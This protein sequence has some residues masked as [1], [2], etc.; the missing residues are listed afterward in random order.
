MKLNF[1]FYSVLC[2][3]LAFTSLSEAADTGVSNI[4]NRGTVYCGTNRNHHDLA[5]KDPNDNT[6]RGFDAALCRA[7][8]AALLGNKERFEMKPLRIDDAPNSLKTGVIDFMFGE[9]PLPAQTEILSNAMNVDI[10]Y[11]E[12]VM[13]L[14]HK[15][16]GATSLEAYKDNK[17]CLVR[18]SIDTYYLNNFNYQYKLDLK[19]LY[20]STRDKATEAFYLNRCVLLPGSSNELKT[21]LNTKFKGKDYVELLPE[22]IGLRPVYLM[23]DKSS[24]NLAVTAKWIINALRLAENYDIN[25][26]NLPMMLS[27]KDPSVQNLLGNQTEL[28]DKFKIFPTWMR[29]FISEEGNYGEMYQRYLGPGTALDLDIMESERGLAMPKPFI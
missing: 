15:I 5:Y 12:K 4:Q 22:V 17:I 8:A 20:F 7:F 11:Y 6:W 9:F 16:E 13:L 24:P 21:I 10:L 1:L 28:W 19:P 25:S 2:G 18:S 3:C 27:D 29:K 23:V 26:N 14:A